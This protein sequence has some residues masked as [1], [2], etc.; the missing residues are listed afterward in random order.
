M[1]D[2]DNLKQYADSSPYVITVARRKPVKSKSKQKVYS[3]V[4]EEYSNDISNEYS[5]DVSEEYLND[6]PDLYSDDVPDQYSDAML[7]STFDSAQSARRSNPLLKLT[8]IGIKGINAIPKFL[9]GKDEEKPKRSY[10]EEVETVIKCPQGT[11]LV[12]DHCKIF[13]NFHFDNNKAAQ[14]KKVIT[15]SD[16]YMDDD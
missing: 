6:V 4:L 13:D 7:S 2:L 5:D 16:I 12:D 11:A 8:N 9:F 15:K 3:D 1:T 10:Y 14:I